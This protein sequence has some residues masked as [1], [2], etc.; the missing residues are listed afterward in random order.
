MAVNNNFLYRKKLTLNLYNK[1]PYKEKGTKSSLIHPIIYGFKGLTQSNYIQCDDNDLLLDY[2]SK[3]SLGIYIPLSTFDKIRDTNIM[4]NLQEFN[5]L[6]DNADRDYKTYTPT[7]FTVKLNPTPYDIPPYVSC[8]SIKNVKFIFI[9]H[10]RFPIHYRLQKVLQTEDITFINWLL[11]Q[12]INIGTQLLYDNNTLTICNIT[13]NEINYIINNSTTESYSLE[14]K[15]DIYLYTISNTYNIRQNSVLYISIDEL[16][17]NLFSSNTNNN[18]KYLFKFFPKYKL[19]KHILLIP[20]DGNKIYKNSLLENINKLTIKFL[21]EN[22]NLINIPLLDT[23]IKK[24][25]SFVNW[26]R[27]PLNP[28]WQI[29]ILFRFGV[30]EI[31]FANSKFTRR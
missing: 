3:N 29:H 11:T 18:F 22:G 24:N 2:N 15:K 20:S 6:I 30:Y 16:N 28:L 31:H 10:I 27:H 5:M 14:N 9:D 4:N 7:N 19:G 25:N 12:N 26:I 13:N 17:D 21:D 1:G 8:N 23:T